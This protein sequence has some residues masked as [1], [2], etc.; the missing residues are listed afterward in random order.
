M[1]ASRPQPFV[2]HPKSL[3]SSNINKLAPDTLRNEYV[4]ERE[5]KHEGKAKQGR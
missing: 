3:Q 5:Y 2:V 1:T 4:L